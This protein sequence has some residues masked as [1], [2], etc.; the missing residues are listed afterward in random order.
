MKNIT[1]KKN[2]NAYIEQLFNPPKNTSYSHLPLKIH[3]LLLLL[4]RVYIISMLYII[5]F[6]TKNIESQRNLLLIT[7]H[8]CQ[9]KVIEV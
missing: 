9:G 5:M 1:K 7:L 6:A 2:E 4:T 3:L 8:I